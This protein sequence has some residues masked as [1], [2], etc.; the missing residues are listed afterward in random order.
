MKQKPGYGLAPSSDHQEKG[1]VEARL[2]V[3]SLSKDSVYE[4]RGYGVL[5]FAELIEKSDGLG[6]VSN[7]EQSVMQARK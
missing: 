1:L 2:C 4:V 6:E 3:W 5:G 7:I